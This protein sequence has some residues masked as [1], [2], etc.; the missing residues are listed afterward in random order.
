MPRVRRSPELCTSTPDRS[1]LCPVWFARAVPSRV[2]TPSVPLS[3]C[4][5]IRRFLLRLLGPPCSAEPPTSSVWRS[6]V[7]LHQRCFVRDVR[8]DYAPRTR[9]S[10]SRVSRPRR[11]SG[12]RQLPELSPAGRAAGL[13]RDEFAVYVNC[14]VWLS[15]ERGG[16]PNLV[17]DA[18]RSYAPQG[19]GLG[20]RAVMRRSSERCT[21]RP[22]ALGGNGRWDEMA[23]QR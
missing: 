1:E 17:R 16:V 19:S 8:P 6:D 23:S 21:S 3:R 2:R 22:R 10:V 15:G 9:P 20:A 13:V 14:V 4:L 18:L 5:E 7:A 11:R 12:E